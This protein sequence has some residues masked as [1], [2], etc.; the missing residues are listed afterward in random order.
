MRS[1]PGEHA[2]ERGLP[3]IISACAERS[4]GSL[5][6]P[7]MNGDHLRV[8]GAVRAIRFRREGP[9]GSSPRVRS[10]RQPSGRRASPVGIISACAERSSPT[11]TYPSATRDHLR[12]CG[13]I[14]TNEHLSVRDAGSSPRVRSDLDGPFP[15]PHR[16]GIISACAERSTH[17]SPATNQKRDH[18]R[19]CGAIWLPVVQ[20]QRVLG[21]SPRVRSD[22]DSQGRAACS[23][24][25]ISACA[26]RSTRYE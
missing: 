12:V 6:S 17:P 11:N 21:S 20:E 2:H 1:G 25:I 16:V 13:A 14:L 9:A 8:C 18:L 7:T 26:E 3:G 24:G 22:P 5:N 4:E 15:L 10:G 23:T 19:V